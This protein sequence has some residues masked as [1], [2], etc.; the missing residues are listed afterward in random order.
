MKSLDETLFQVNCLL[1]KIMNGLRLYFMMFYLL[2][3]SSAEMTVCQTMRSDNES[4]YNQ[5]SFIFIEKDDLKKEQKGNNDTKAE[6]GEKGEKGEI[7]KKGE[8]G[9]VCQTNQ[10]EINQLKHRIRGLLVNSLL[11]I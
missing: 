2:K 7:G 8:K 9:D 1:Y 5:Q 6:K 3:E 11:V 10:T 4:E